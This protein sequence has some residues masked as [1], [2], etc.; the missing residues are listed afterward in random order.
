MN[1]ISHWTSWTA[2]LIS[3]LVITFGVI[4][5]FFNCWPN[6]IY[7][8][9]I[10][11]ECLVLGLSIK[12]VGTLFKTINVHDWNQLGILLAIF[13]IRTMIKQQLNWDL[14]LETF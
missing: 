4:K 8:R 12:L 1:P 10:L 2:E 9:K 5:S 7:S 14:N 13:G 3:N 11:S 6:P